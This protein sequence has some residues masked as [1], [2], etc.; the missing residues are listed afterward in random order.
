M[1]LVRMIFFVF[2]RERKH[3]DALRQW[4]MAMAS[5]GGNSGLEVVYHEILKMFCS[6]TMKF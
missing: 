5:V 3:S 1:I 2:Q 6:F 4:K